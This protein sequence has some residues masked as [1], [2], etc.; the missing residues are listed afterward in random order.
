MGGGQRLVQPAG[1]PLSALVLVLVLVLVV[2]G[3]LGQRTVLRRRRRVAGR[4]SSRRPRQA[5]L[6]KPAT[7]TAQT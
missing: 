7:L 1:Q 6:I 3:R 4:R 5:L 2:G